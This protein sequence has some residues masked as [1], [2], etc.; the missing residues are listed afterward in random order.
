[1][2]GSVSGL[3]LPSEQC[4]PSEDSEPS[5]ACPACS[6]PSSGRSPPSIWAPQAAAD[7]RSAASVVSDP[8]LIRELRNWLFPDGVPPTGVHEN[9]HRH[10]RFRAW[11]W[12]RQVPEAVA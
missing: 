10:V 12:W 11:L 6:D 8:C 3:P 4:E 1:P 2:S 7:A 5:G 9:R